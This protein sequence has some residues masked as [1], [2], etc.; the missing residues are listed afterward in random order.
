MYHNSNKNEK[1]ME[2]I[3]YSSKGFWRGLT[4][5]NKLSKEAKVSKRQ[6]LDFLKKQAIWRIYLPAPKKLVR[7]SFDVSTPNEVHQAGLLFL[8]VGR[9]TYKYALTVVDIASRYKEAEP[10]TSKDSKEVAQAF[11]TIYKRHLTY[12]KLLQVDPGREFMVAVSQF[13][14]KHNVKIRRGRPEIHRD[15]IIVERFN[16]TL[17]ERLFGYQYAKEIE[18]PHTRNREWVKRLPGVRKAINTETKKPPPIRTRTPAEQICPNA[19]VRYLYQPGEQ[20]GGGRRRATDPIW[21]VDIHKISHH[22]ILQGI[23][24][25]YLNEPAPQRG[26]VKEELLIVP[27]DT[28]T[29]MS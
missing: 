24:V 29:R 3:Y 25:Y 1:I 23:R 9:K 21:S 28:Q 14:K 20:E 19:S 11:D 12:P 16:R 2:S 13:M 26:F 22:I 6:A 10:L 4:A 17:A 27:V 18:N 15:Q 7:P 5:A 8:K